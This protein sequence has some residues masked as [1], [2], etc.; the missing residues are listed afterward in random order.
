MQA[1]RTMQLIDSLFYPAVDKSKPQ[2]TSA[3][4]AAEEGTGEGANADANEDAGGAD[5]KRND[6]EEGKMIEMQDMVMNPMSSSRGSSSSSSSIPKGVEDG[7][8]SDNKHTGE[9]SSSS[10]RGS[11]SGVHGGAIGSRT[12]NPL[13]STGKK[14]RDSMAQDS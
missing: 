2:S 3:A 12:G 10:A 11:N 9:N 4:A 13:F 7:A 1:F 6:Q 8:I 14:K 5:G